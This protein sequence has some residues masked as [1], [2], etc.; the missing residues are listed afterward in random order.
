MTIPLVHYKLDD[1]AASTD[2]AD[3]SGNG[4]HGTAVRNTEL[5]TV[6]GQIGFAGLGSLQTDEGM[7]CP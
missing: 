1:N 2:V 3:V 5:W 4:N 7:K 6:A